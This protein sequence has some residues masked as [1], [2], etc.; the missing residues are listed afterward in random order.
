MP[1]NQVH[2]AVGQVG[3][4]VWA[5]IR[6]AIFPQT[7]RDV[8]PREALAER[9]LDVRISLVIAQQNVEARLLLLDEVVLERQRFFVVGDD[10]VVHIDRLAHQS[11]GLGILETAL[12][13]STSS[14]GCA[15]CWPCPHK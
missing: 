15:G 11:V 5:V 12:R 9:E 14:P 4:E 13:E 3:R 6:A 8:N 10:D 2:D 1:V 7:A